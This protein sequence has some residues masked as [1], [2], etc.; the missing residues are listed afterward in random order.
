M[1][2]TET[3]ISKEKIIEEFVGYFKNSISIPDFKIDGIM[4]VYNFRF[5]NNFICKFGKKG[6]I[7]KYNLTDAETLNIKKRIK[8]IK[9]TELYKK[10]VADYEAFEIRRK[11]IGVTD[12]LI[13]KLFH[14]C[15]DLNFTNLKTNQKTRISHNIYSS[16]R[17]KIAK[18]IVKCIDNG[19]LDLKNVT[20]SISLDTMALFN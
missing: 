15:Y 18:K 8:D 13:D 9:K 16:S 19:E 12:K 14:G 20:F 2:N 11:Q 10:N 3:I 4:D 5:Y 6:S 7:E 17:Y 1:V